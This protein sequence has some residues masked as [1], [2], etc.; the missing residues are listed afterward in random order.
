[1]FRTSRAYSS[2]VYK[3]KPIDRLI[4]RQAQKELRRDWR[5]AAELLDPA[6]SYF[7]NSSAASL[8]P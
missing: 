7:I 4:I 3:V 5:V 1:M 2:A 6:R 8:A